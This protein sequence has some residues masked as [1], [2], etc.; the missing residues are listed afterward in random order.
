[1]LQDIPDH[2]ETRV[3][4]KPLN[5]IPNPPAEDG[6]NLFLY[7]I[8]P[9]M[10]YRNHDL[11]T[12]NSAGMLVRESVSIGIDLSYLLTAFC[13]Q[14][15]PS[16]LN[17]QML[18]ANAILTLDEFCILTKGIIS[19]QAE[20]VGSDLDQ[21]VER[22]RLSMLNLS[23]DDLTKIWSSFAEGTPYK[24]SIAYFASVVILDRRFPV[25][26]PLPVQKPALYVQ[27][28]R[29]S[30]INSIDPIHV[31]YSLEPRIVVRGINLAYSDIRLDFGENLPITEMPRPIS[32]INNDTIRAVVPVDPNKGSLNL[33]TKYLKVISPMMMGEPKVEHKGTESNVAIFE[34]VPKIEEINVTQVSPGSSVTITVSP[35]IQPGEAVNV[36]I[37]HFKPIPVKILELG[38][39][40]VEDAVIGPTNHLVIKI[41]DLPPEYLN[42]SYSLR[43]QING[44]NSA[45][46]V[47][48]NENDPNYNKVIPFIEIIQP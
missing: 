25:S 2:I 11:P 18:L 22:I 31:E 10:A 40:I 30:R 48:R 21:Q 14:D 32:V 20:T 17:D 27:Q 12:H 26:P 1:M 24:T 36:I 29:V 7:H 46:S 5:E 44:I 38:E 8:T 4:S 45:L 19:N 15:D 13:K 23:I 9:N 47:E 33:G 37:G 3:M 16:R 41:P 34:L 28:H 42:H 39:E 6:I 43:V 35:T